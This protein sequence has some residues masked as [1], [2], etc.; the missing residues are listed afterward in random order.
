MVARMVVVGEAWKN[1]FGVRQ[2]KHLS[3]HNTRPLAAP[4]TAQGPLYGKNVVDRTREVWRKGRP[5][6][7]PPCI[8]TCLTSTLGISIKRITVLGVRGVP[9]R[10]LRGKQVLKLLWRRVRQVLKLNGARR[11]RLGREAAEVILRGNVAENGAQGWSQ[12]VA[13]NE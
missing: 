2:G 6:R 4:A 5:P 9:P 8:T 7:F 12:G 11:S 13:G 1:A 3:H 10:H